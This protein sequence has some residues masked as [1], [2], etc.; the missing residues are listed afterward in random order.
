MTTEAFGFGINAVGGSTLVSVRNP[1]ELTAALGTVGDKEI[2][3]NNIDGK[4]IELQEGIYDFTPRRNFL[5]KVMTH[6]EKTTIRGKAGATVILKNFQFLIDLDKK[7]RLVIENI[8]FR[9]DG[10]ATG[11]PD[12]FDLVA[13]VPGA[14]ETARTERSSIRFTQCSFDGHADIAI[15][16][17]NVTGRRQL[18]VTVDHCLFFDAR[19][20]LSGAGSA[21][22]V[23]RGAINEDVN[24]NDKNA[25][26]VPGNS[27]FTVANN[28][29]IDVWRRSPRVAEDNFAHI[30]NNLLYRW[31]YTAKISTDRQ[32]PDG[33]WRGMEVGGGNTGKAG[34]PNGTAVIQANRFIPWKKK[35]DPCAAITV[36]QQ[37]TVDFGGLDFPNQ[38]DD[39]DGANGSN[40]FDAG[41]T[42][43]LQQLYKTE[44]IDVPMPAPAATMDWN[45][46]LETVGPDALRATTGSAELRGAND[47]RARLRSVLAGTTVS[48]DDDE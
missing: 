22:Y 4:I 26:R 15:D 7:N 17:H 6:G 46:L 25:Q 39:P 48:S 34:Q 12:G 41:T 37:T 21:P 44:D 5:R 10:V 31:G 2:A 32:N 11:T 19:P 40:P 13:T 35:T 3:A 27:K 42:I 23:N 24:R 28:V 30:F 45:A 20:G 33:T 18:L 16:S 47:P 38:Y 14:K 8:A 1:D 29:F 43:P 9:S 36:H